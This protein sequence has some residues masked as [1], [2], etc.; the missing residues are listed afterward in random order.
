MV[1]SLLFIPAGL[2][3]LVYGIATGD[4]HAVAFG[5]ILPTVGA[6]SMLEEGMIG[7]FNPNKGKRR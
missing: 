4:G 5:L 6:L 7:P 2:A 3:L 1:L